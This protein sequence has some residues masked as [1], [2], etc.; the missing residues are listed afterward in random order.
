MG[1]STIARTAF[2]AVCAASLSLPGTADAELAPE[3]AT[4]DVVSVPLG[5]GDGRV[6]ERDAR[7]FSAW[8]VWGFEQ[9]AA[10]EGV[11]LELGAD[12]EARML[13]FWVFA[14]SEVPPETKGIVS[15]ADVLW[16]RIQE[17]AAADAARRQALVEEFGVF[18][19]ETWGAELIAPTVEYLGGALAPESYAALVQE[20]IARSAPQRGATGGSSSDPRMADGSYEA[21]PNGGQD[22]IINDGSGDIMYVDP[23]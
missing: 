8:C 1:W 15:Q 19:V 20:A 21:A 7:A 12:G 9:L 10:S 14:W 4:L 6:T 11:E 3:G 18:A 16:P 22:Y 13:D 2:R 17:A 5:S 23:Q